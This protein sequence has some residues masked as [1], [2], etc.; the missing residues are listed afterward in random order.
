MIHLIIDDVKVDNLVKVAFAKSFHCKVIIIPFVIIK[1]SRE[2]ILWNYAHFLFVCLFFAAPQGLQYLSSPT[3][4]WTPATAVKT[5]DPKPLDHQ[6][7]PSCLFFKSNF[8]SVI[9]TFI[10][11]WNNNY[12]GTC[13]MV[14]VE[15][16]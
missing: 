8:Y 12:F 11:T 14:K 7:T 3:R 16:F 5:P 9:L 2:K 10:D 6:R 4:D 15:W 1:L 13:Q